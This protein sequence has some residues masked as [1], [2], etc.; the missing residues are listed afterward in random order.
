M[1]NM[2]IPEVNVISTCSYSPDVPRIANPVTFLSTA[3]R[4][5][6]ATTACSDYFEANDWLKKYEHFMRME[7]MSQSYKSW[8]LFGS[9]FVEI[10]PIFIF[11]QTFP[12][13]TAST[14]LLN[15]NF[16]YFR[17]CSILS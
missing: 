17:V 15:V 11:L 13:A 5:F 10:H 8:I 1:C 14:D 3:L 9:Q 4:R 2:E 12:Q 7:C 6:L 16:G